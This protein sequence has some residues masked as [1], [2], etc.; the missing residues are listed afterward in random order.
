MIS[1]RKLA[2]GD[3][4]EIACRGVRPV[5]FLSK[6]YGREKEST[7]DGKE[8]LAYDGE[9]EVIVNRYDIVYVIG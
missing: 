8:A 9:D 5:C 3:F 7:H 2:T 6:S 1:T 4:E